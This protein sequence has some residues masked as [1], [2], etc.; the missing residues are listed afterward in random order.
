MYM[1]WTRTKLETFCIQSRHSNHSVIHMYVLTLGHMAKYWHL[2]IDR[3]YGYHWN[4]LML[5]YIHILFVNCSWSPSILYLINSVCLTLFS[6]RSITQNKYS[7]PWIDRHPFLTHMFCIFMKCYTIRR[8]WGN[9]F[10]LDEKSRN[11]KLQ[12]HQRYSLTVTIKSICQ[13]HKQNISENKMY[14]VFLV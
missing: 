6:M 12:Q 9:P 2:F 8:S 1:T 5:I 13:Y 3:P 14:C 11:I 7:A 10:P 4:S